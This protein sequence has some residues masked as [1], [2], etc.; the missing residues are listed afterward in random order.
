MRKDFS[1]EALPRRGP[2]DLCCAVAVIR[3]TYIYRRS[4]NWHSVPQYDLWPQ[5]HM[6]LTTQMDTTP[7][8]RL[9]LHHNERQ[10]ESRACEKKDDATF[11]LQAYQCY[12]ALNFCKSRRCILELKFE[13][14][15]I[16]NIHAYEYNFINCV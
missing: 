16:C 13:R 6:S 10:R 15:H 3:V 9:P 14:K 5:Q 7:V 12:C 4:C 1:N 11:V 2:D 8:T